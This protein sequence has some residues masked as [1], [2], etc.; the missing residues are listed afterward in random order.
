[1]KKNDLTSLVVHFTEWFSGMAFLNVCWLL[2][3]LPIV[4]I[5]PATNAVFEVVYEWKQ[6]GKP[7]HLYTQFKK[8]F[9]KQIKR[10]FK[11]GLPIFVALLVSAIDI[12]FLSTLTIE[13][14]W[15]PILKYAFYTV[16]VV[17][18]LTILFAMPLSKIYR[19]DSLQILVIGFLTAA[20][21]PLITLA[22]LAS[23]VCMAL[24]IAFF[25]AMFFFLSMSGIAWVGT[26]AA[27]YSLEKEI[28]D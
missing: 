5:I 11:L 10:S 28:E 23:L 7:K 25:P 14:T 8:Y 9:F 1:M 13:A 27:L 20:G 3:S 21:K 19:N 2:F 22:V 17:I 6:K 12:Y 24:V 4:T 26:T 18:I 15:F 16:T